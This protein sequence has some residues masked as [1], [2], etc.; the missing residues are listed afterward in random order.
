MKDDLQKK[1]KVDEVNETEKAM[2]EDGEKEKKGEEKEEETKEQGSYRSWKV[3]EFCPRSWKSHGKL[4]TCKYFFT[5]K[6]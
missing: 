2:K 5:V 3:M 4:S 1:A 6:A